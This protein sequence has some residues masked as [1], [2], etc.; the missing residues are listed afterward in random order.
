[1]AFSYIYHMLNIDSSANN[2]YK[3]HYT[4]INQNAV[5]S[6]TNNNTSNNTNNNTNTNTNTNTNNN[7]NNNTNTNNNNNNNNNTM[8]F[9]NKYKIHLLIIIIIILC[10]L[11]FLIVK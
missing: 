2:I 10:M 8:E 5:I 11:G 7:T 4:Q 1:M 3:T 6:N 9:I